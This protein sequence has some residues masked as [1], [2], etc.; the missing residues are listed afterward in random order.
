[1]Q[2]LYNMCRLSCFG[3]EIIIIYG[4]RVF[5]AVGDGSTGTRK[6]G[7]STNNGINWNLTTNNDGLFTSFT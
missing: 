2:S 1:M 6:L 3:G 4:N 7:Y 5:V